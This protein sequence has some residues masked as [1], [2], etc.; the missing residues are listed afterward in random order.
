MDPTCPVETE[1]T[2]LSP[3]IVTTSSPRPVKE[4]GDVT[5]NDVG[6]PDSIGRALF[7]ALQ[8]NQTGNQLPAMRI[9]RGSRGRLVIT[10]VIWRRA[11]NNQVRSSLLPKSDGEPYVRGQYLELTEYCCTC[12]DKQQ[13]EWSNPCRWN[14]SKCTSRP[15]IW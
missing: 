2:T 6:I 3:M 9:S 7:D 4:E 12:T 15:S 8:Q 10:A 13:K 5:L 1:E 11:R 14:R